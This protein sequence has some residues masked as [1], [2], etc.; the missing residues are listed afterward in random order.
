MTINQQY[1]QTLDYLYQQLPMFQ[2]VGPVAFKKDLANI[3]ALADMLGQ[4]QKQF[5]T[6][7]IAG[8]NGK[9]SVAHM[10]SAILQ[11]QGY[12]TGLYTSPH[13]HDFRERIKID[14]RWVEKAYIVDFVKQYKKRFTPIQPSYF[15]INVAMA[16]E[17]FAK[18][19]VDIAVIETGLGGRLDST[20]IIHPLISIITN[21]SFDHVN[22]L[23]N[24]L[25]AIASEKAGIIKPKIPIVIGETHPE[26]K[27][28]FEKKAIEL[29]SP[30]LFAD[31]H[32]QAELVS[33]TLEHS[34]FNIFKEGQLK[35]ANLK[36][37]LLGAYQT[38]NL[39]TVLQSVDQLKS[40]GLEIE[41]TALR[42]G[43]LNLKKLANFIGRW[44][45]LGHKPLIIVD[46]AHNE[47]GLRLVMAQLKALAY[48]RL[49]FVFGTVSDKDVGPVLSLLPTDARYYFAKANIPRGMNPKMLQAKAQSYDLQGRTYIS[50]K[51]AFQAAKKKAQPDDLIFVGGS[52]FVVGE[53]LKN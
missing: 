27:A 32:Y 26:T 41:E 13:Y 42:K 4:P 50:V 34:H 15:E 52:I 11:A 2:R 16:F 14:G 1:K 44:Q 3:L 12:K 48:N 31:Q 5:P 22:F 7:H 24:T 46:S 53:I 38:K 49:H 18:Q 45:V 43:L 29:G 37:N 40:V 6:I 28:V 19:K 25:P 10:L 39:L 47:A 35:F 23:G 33:T 20:N 21:I 8:T 9:G 30:I 17:Y 51:N 36:A